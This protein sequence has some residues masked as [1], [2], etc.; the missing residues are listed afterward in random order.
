MLQFCQQILQK[1]P[2]NYVWGYP[3]NK[4]DFPPSEETQHWWQARLQWNSK[5][6][7]FI[8]IPE[9]ERN[10]YWA[11]KKPAH[12]PEHCIQMGLVILKH[13]HNL[14]ERCMWK[15]IPARSETQVRSECVQRPGV[16][17]DRTGHPTDY[18]CIDRGRTV[19][20]SGHTW[21]GLA[22][23]HCFIAIEKILARKPESA[24]LLVKTS[25][26]L[27]PAH[28]SSFPNDQNDHLEAVRFNLTQSP[29]GSLESILC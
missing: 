14:N 5:K 27:S 21:L 15:P 11:L 17:L 12:F 24:V 8:R 6:K 26:G 9:P 13:S 2:L 20:K 10:Y 7:N 23:P 29:T 28:P 19:R 16:N 22:S 1:D 18:W 25:T 3:S 4:A